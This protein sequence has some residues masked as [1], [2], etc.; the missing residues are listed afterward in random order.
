MNI[1]KNILVMTL[2]MVMSASFSYA[3]KDHGHK[4]KKGEKHAVKKTLQ[5]V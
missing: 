1:V 3:G 5:R 4:H 2:L